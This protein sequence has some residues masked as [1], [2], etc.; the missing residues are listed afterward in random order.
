MQV[1]HPSEISEDLMEAFTRYCLPLQS[2]IS[3]STLFKS[4]HVKLLMQII[5]YMAH[6][7]SHACNINHPIPRGNSQKVHRPHTNQ[8]ARRV[9]QTTTPPA[10]P[11]MI[12][13]GPTS[14]AWCKYYSRKHNHPKC[15]FYCSVGS[16]V[17]G[18]VTCTHFSF[19]RVSHTMGTSWPSIYF[20]FLV[21]PTQ[22]KASVKLQPSIYFDFR[23]EALPFVSSGAHTKNT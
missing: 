5:I 4:C 2:M 8:N 22:N 11:P 20:D 17:L 6:V 16:C 7:T 21:G 14:C 1:L 15:M 19:G 18:A 23:L 3:C 9:Q 12:V 10:S 13:F